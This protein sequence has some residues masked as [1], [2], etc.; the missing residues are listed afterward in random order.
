MAIDNEVRQSLGPTIS[1]VVRAGT[2]V[3]TALRDF[4][5]AYYLAHLA[6]GDQVY[7]NVLN[8]KR[9]YGKEFKSAEKFEEYNL[10]DKNSRTGSFGLDKKDRDF[11]ASECKRMNA[12][13]SLSKRPKNFDELYDRKFNRGEELSDKDEKLLNT[14]LRREPVFDQKGN[15]MLDK[16]GIPF[17]NYKLGK[18]GKPQIIEG[19]YIL[20]I[21]ECDIPKWEY[22]CR[23]LEARGRAKHPLKTRL[24]SLKVESLKRTQKAPERDIEK[25]KQRTKTKGAERER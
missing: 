22:I 2:S 11:I 10:I 18:D 13:Y 7:N 14:F 8:G 5:N 21:A 17:M 6:H 3:L 1:I 4:L 15:P 20:R 19:E 23:K 9:Q 25:T 16:N 24:Q 12:N